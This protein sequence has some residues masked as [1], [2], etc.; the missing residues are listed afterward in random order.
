MT[1]IWHL[2]MLYNTVFG[3]HEWLLSI[4]VHCCTC[5]QIRHFPDIVLLDNAHAGYVATFG[6]LEMHPYLQLP[7]DPQE[8]S[9]AT[10]HVWCAPVQRT[11][12][13]PCAR[14]SAAALAR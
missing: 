2:L 11:S 8:G 13:R 3:I 1:T 14:I 7:A 4:L 5:C 12:S 10:L 6:F 9:R